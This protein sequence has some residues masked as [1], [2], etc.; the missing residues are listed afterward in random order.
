MFFSAAQGMISLLSEDT[1]IGFIESLENGIIQEG[2]LS[3]ATAGPMMMLSL[4]HDLQN[5]LFKKYKFDPTQ[6]LEGVVPALGC[7]Q[8]R[9]NGETF[10]FAHQATETL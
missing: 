4:F 8:A 1:R 5:P 6:F 9:L 7:A 3:Q 2:V 10:D